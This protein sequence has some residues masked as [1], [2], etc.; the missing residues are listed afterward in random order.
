[1]GFLLVK[2]LLA[3]FGSQLYHLIRPNE[4]VDT[5]VFEDEADRLA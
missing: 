5:V 3:D 2:V 4:Q 1:M